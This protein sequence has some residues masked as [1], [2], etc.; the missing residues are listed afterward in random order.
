[1]IAWPISVPTKAPGQ[2]L[3]EIV[4]KPVVGQQSDRP[5][6]ETV[7][8]ECRFE[9]TNLLQRGNR[10]AQSQRKPAEDLQIVRAGGRMDACVVPALLEQAI[11]G[12]HCLADAGVTEGGRRF[13]ARR[14]LLGVARGGDRIDGAPIDR[15]ARRPGHD[16]ADR[17]DD[18]GRETKRLEPQFRVGR[19]RLHSPARRIT[20]CQ[21]RAPGEYTKPQMARCQQLGKLVVGKCGSI[22]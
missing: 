19:Q 8:G 17:Q 1:M 15:A 18:D 10:A 5:P 9:F 16:D 14:T 13:T 11:Q 4:G 12:R 6:I 20:L 3:G 2:P 7:G 22:K 21:R